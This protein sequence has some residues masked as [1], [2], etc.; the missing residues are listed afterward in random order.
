MKVIGS[1]S[2]PPVNAA[3]IASFY[4][5][6]GI[7]SQEKEL[8]SELT[9]FISKVVLEEKFTGELGKT[10]IIRTGCDYSTATK[11]IL[12]GAGEKE[13]LN[14]NR[15]RKI[16]SIAVSTAEKERLDN[17]SMLLPDKDYILLKTAKAITESAY[18]TAY[19]FDK[20][21]SS[22][23]DYSG[24]QNLQIISPSD[25]ARLVNFYQGICSQGI[26]LGTITANA[27]TLARNIASEPAKYMTPEILAQVAQQVARD[28]NL[29]IKILTKKDC[30][31]LGM[32]SFLAVSE[33][34]DK[35]PR[36]IVI[37]YTPQ[38][39]P[40]K[41][42]AIVGKGVTF[43]SGGLSI[44]PSDG[45]ATMKCDKSGA[46]AV[47]GV[48]STMKKFHP[49]SKIT[50]IAPAVE[51]MTG[52]G[53]MK[54]G[55]IVTAMN[56][57]TIEILNTDAE[58]RLILADAIAYAVR[59]GADEIIDIATLTGACKVALGDDI[60]G[61]MTNSDP[62]AQKVITA[63]N[64]AGEDMWQLPIRDSN[65][66]SIKSNVADMKN[67]GDKGLAGAQTGFVFL[68]RFTN[69][70]PL[71]HLDIAGPAWPNGAKWPT[72]FGTRA[73]INYLLNHS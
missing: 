11:I 21:K 23:D 17:V 38:A 26:H 53:A 65:R 4:K 7:E 52:G 33:G 29:K 15:I 70:K 12:I 46:A 2:I 54:L 37:T 28:N 3:I 62:F 43:D 22:E 34:S 55:D 71:V 16:A 56:G 19:K 47:I 40:K 68:E 72:G 41:H 1:P 20:Y 66:D 18:F 8:A 67:I 44:K 64:E 58:G 63:G 49:D 45:M 27:Q 30:K 5:G 9:G 36:F 60:A 32:G 6:K 50:M 39:K 42:I 14:L 13:R 24:L 10:L 59:E 31:R 48:M 73:L 25:E 61:V 51:N 35:P 57:K 69:D